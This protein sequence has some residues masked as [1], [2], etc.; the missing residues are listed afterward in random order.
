MKTSC[1]AV[2]L[3]ITMAFGASGRVATQEKIPLLSRDGWLD[4]WAVTVVGCIAQGTSA[5]DY[6]L[7]TSIPQPEATDKDATKS[8][9]LV[10][11]SIEV[12]LSQHVGHTVSVT[13]VHAANLVTGTTGTTNSKKPVSEGAVKDDDK[14]MTGTFAVKSLK[15]VAASCSRR[16]E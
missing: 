11:T 5:G 7:T 14:K 15:M 4:P 16:A 1:F 3:G 10:L 13:G 12:D 2:A 9:K 6:T 8:I